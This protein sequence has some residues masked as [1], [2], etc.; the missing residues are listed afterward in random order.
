MTPS[1]SLSNV[2]NAR[3][4]AAGGIRSL[5]KEIPYATAAGGAKPIGLPIGGFAIEDIVDISSNKQP[6]STAAAASDEWAGWTEMPSGLPSA[7]DPALQAKSGDYATVREVL[8]QY[9]NRMQTIAK[10]ATNT[11]LTNEERTA[12]SREF[13]LIKGHVNVWVQLA[14]D[15]A[16][17]AIPSEG[18]MGFVGL[19]W[20]GNGWGNPAGFFNANVNSADAAMKAYDTL[21]YTQSLASTTFE[22]IE[23]LQAANI[24]TAQP[25]TGGFSASAAAIDETPRVGPGFLMP[26]V[27]PSADAAAIPQAGPGLLMPSGLPSAID[28]EMRS[29]AANLDSWMSVAR[30]YLGRM[31]ELAKQASD[32]SLSNAQRGYLNQEFELIKGHLNAWANLAGDESDFFGGSNEANYSDIIGIIWGN[33]AG[34]FETDISSVDGATNAL[35]T[36]NVTQQRAADAEASINIR[37]TTLNFIDQAQ[38]AIK[39]LRG[40]ANANPEQVGITKVGEPLNDF[41]SAFGQLHLLRERLGDGFVTEARYNELTGIFL[42]TGFYTADASNID[43]A[44][45]MLSSQLDEYRAR[46]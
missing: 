9:L 43:D 37:S 35:D 36:L 5:S 39:N 44:L 1:L 3:E 45:S 17:Y 12:L 14:N 28:P 24:A 11:E 23:K 41:Q 2:F 26:D 46:A 42:N 34:F 27:V 19:V 21:D 4:T 18:G 15:N 29:Q 13:E 32:P 10:E 33:N 8:Q 22:S 25:A 6:E 7:V 40:L 30:Q 31:Q 16:T 38:D 20:G